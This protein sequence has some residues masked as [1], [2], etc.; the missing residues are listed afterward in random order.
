ML[1]RLGVR[2][3]P[4]GRGNSRIGAA[5]ISR[6]LPW[7]TESREMH[8][9]QHVTMRPHQ[10]QAMP[11]HTSR[12]AYE[13]ASRR[14]STG[15]PR[16]HGDSRAVAMC[17]VPVISCC[18][19]A[20]TGHSDVLP[21]IGVHCCGTVGCPSSSPKTCGTFALFYCNTLHSRPSFLT[22]IDHDTILSI[23]STATLAHNPTFIAFWR[24]TD[25]SISQARWTSVVGL[26][27]D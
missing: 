2:P 25:R 10:S 26:R 6:T 14:C 1:S 11:Q 27:L 23:L 5:Q 15:R 12:A 22:F 7:S 18:T 9:L 8:G 17:R 13:H 3:D 24:S 19:P 16:Y 20:L 21:S 4:H